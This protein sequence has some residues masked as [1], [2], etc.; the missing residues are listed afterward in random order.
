MKKYALIVAGGSGARMGGD[1]PKQ[2]LQ[3]QNQ[4][5]LMHTIARFYDFDADIAIT[6]VLPPSQLSYWNKLCVQCDF[7]LPHRVVSGGDSRFQSVKNGLNTLVGEGVVFIHD[8]VRPFVSAATLGRCLSTALEKGNALP[9][10]PLIDS[11]RVV[12][13]HGSQHKNRSDY[14]L[15][16]TPQTFRLSDIKAAF[17]QE[18]SPLFTD[19]AS[20][21]EG[22][23]GSIHLV[24]GNV[25]NMKITR[26]IDLKIAELLLHSLG[27]L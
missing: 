27:E 16:Q 10:M 20:V 4:A 21:L 8:G 6:V 23:G 19:D 24:E 2:F 26:P 25:E 18:E 7:N 3:L 22:A 17:Q 13:A 12:S 15:V 14:R 5:V 1:T 9:V 11:I